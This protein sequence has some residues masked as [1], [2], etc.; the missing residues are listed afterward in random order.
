[1]NYKELGQVGQ[2]KDL[3]KWVA[4]LTRFNNGKP[5]NKDLIGKIEDFFDYYWQHNRMQALKSE[6]DQRF[7]DEL[8]Y[9]VQSEIIIDYLWNDFLYKYRSYFTALKP[10]KENKLT[11][12]FKTKN[13]RGFICNFVKVLE[14]RFYSNTSEDIIQD[15][16]EECFEAIFVTKGCVGVGYRLFNQKFFGTQIVMS[17]KRKT[18]NVIN[19]YS[20]LYEKCGEFLYQP[21]DFV[22]AY[23][24]RKENFL[25]VMHEKF[26]K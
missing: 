6:E 26:G 12:A 20:L 1:M 19:D 14:P 21:F 11:E 24:M 2:H 7:M 23:A 13:L 3:S 17:K 8:P 10:L 15:Q 16:Y 9:N 25:S 18:I 4:L 5:L 22:E